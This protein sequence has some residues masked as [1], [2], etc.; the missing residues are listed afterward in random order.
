MSL[1]QKL[2]DMGWMFFL[3]HGVMIIGL[4]LLV[5]FCLDFYERNVRIKEDTHNV[6]LMHRYLWLRMHRRYRAKV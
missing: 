1:G 4:S 5:I 3:N 2:L 6:D